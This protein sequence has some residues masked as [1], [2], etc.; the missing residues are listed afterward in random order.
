LSF[1][2]ASREPAVAAKREDL[3]NGIVLTKAVFPSSPAFR[4]NIDFHEDFVPIAKTA[5]YGQSDT[6]TGITVRLVERTR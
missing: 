1:G 4:E 6:R 3:A 5:A 2:L